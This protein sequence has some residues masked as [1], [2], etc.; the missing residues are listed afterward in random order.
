MRLDTTAIRLFDLPAVAVRLSQSH[1]RDSNKYSP[2]F[3][4][5]RY[6]TARDA[7]HNANSLG[8]AQRV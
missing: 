1:D 7:R 2:V 8:D 6:V 5:Q 3:A 4:T